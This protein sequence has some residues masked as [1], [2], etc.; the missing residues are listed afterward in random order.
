[1]TDIKIFP[2]FDQG[3]CTLWHE[4]ARIW[5][6]A[7]IAP[8][9]SLEKRKTE[10]TVMQQFFTQEYRY[11]HVNLVFGAWDQ[12]KMVGFI[13]GSCNDNSATGNRLAVLPRYQSMHIGGTLLSHFERAVSL[14]SKYINLIALESVVRFYLR[15]GYRTTGT[16]EFIKDIRYIA[17]GHVI[18]VFRVPSWV[19]PICRE[20][21]QAYD[22]TWNNG[23]INTGNAPFF[24]Y[25][26]E[27]SCIQGF[28]TI[29][30]SGPLICAKNHNTQIC[31]QLSKTII[32]WMEFMQNGHKR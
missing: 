19:N 32:P 6:D 13:H 1:M 17:S 24:V 22:L 20:I 8:S 15:R 18:P 29:T 12:D 10:I 23:I 14:D 11:N 27:H 4:C 26:D 28:A 5:V 21:A 9:V 3:Q 25:I 16:Y 7:T 2:I 31:D 30:P